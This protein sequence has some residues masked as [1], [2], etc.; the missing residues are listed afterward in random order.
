MLHIAQIVLANCRRK[1]F[2]LCAGLTVE[3]DF[4]STTSI[5]TPDCVF[6]PIYPKRLIAQYK[7]CSY[8]HCR[9]HVVFREKWIRVFE[10]IAVPVVKCDHERI[11]RQRPLVHEC[12]R[13]FEGKY[14]VVLEEVLQLCLKTFWRDK[15]TAIVV[16]ALRELGRDPVIQY[17]RKRISMPKPEQGGQPEIVEDRHREAL[18]AGHYSVLTVGTEQAVLK[19]D[20][21]IRKRIIS[22]GK[23]FR[24]MHVILLSSATGSAVERVGNVTVYP[25]NS[26]GKIMRYFD[27]VRIGKR[28]RGVD[29]VSAQDPFET[30]IAAWLIARYHRA[31]LHVQVHTDFLDPAYAKHSLKNR[32]RVF[33]AG[34]I[35]R[36]A[37]RVR[38]V[39]NR[40]RESVLRRNLS[41]SVSVLPIYIDLERLRNAS[42]PDDLRKKFAGFAHRLLVVSRLEPEKN[43]QL[44]LRAFAA[45]APATSCLMIL[46]TGSESASLKK[47]VESLKLGKRVFFE[48]WKDPA[49]YYVLADLVL[50]PSTYEGY[51]QVII[52][53]LASGKPV[54]STDVGVARDAGAIV[55][56]PETFELSLMEWFEHGSRAG[57]LKDYPYASMDE[58]VRLY[59]EDIGR[60]AQEIAKT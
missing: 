47:T 43:I 45:S 46:G 59:C 37:A 1:R 25:T 6:E 4:L 3:R 33:I 27:A 57:V 26:M 35:L 58:Y 9:R 60:S 2:E 23:Y 16:Y 40:V 49:P 31:P 30:A 13:S 42:A 48:G 12:E 34:F 32:I 36:R 17:D 41:T 7:I 39:S 51:G 18:H 24:E 20:S 29:I 19:L 14:L 28:V 38:V 15:F 22:Y 55:T 11:F 54:L 53:A 8:V 52:E 50:V 44:A 5:A 10:E 21:P 56:D